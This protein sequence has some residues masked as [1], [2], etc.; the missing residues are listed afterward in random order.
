[1]L[2]NFRRKASRTLNR[3]FYRIDREMLTKGFRRI[4]LERGMSV[5]V[6]AALS[7]LGHIDGG[8]D[9]VIDAIMEI[10]GADGAVLMPS[11]PTG[12]STARYLDSG[13]EFDVRNSPSKVGLVSEIFRK[14]EGVDRSLHPTNPVAGWGAGAK[15]FLLDHGKSPTPYG[16]E[17]PYG[18]LAAAENG[19]ILMMETHVHSFLHHLQEMVDFPNLY[20]PGEREVSL[21][22]WDGA[23]RTMRTAVMRT[24]IPYFVAIPAVSGDEPDWAVLHDFALLFPRNQRRIVRRLG[25][26]FDGYKRLYERQ[27]ELER[28]GIFRTTRLGKGEIGLLQAGRFA[29][30]IKPEFSELIERFRRFYDPEEI[31]ARKLPYT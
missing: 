27:A 24:R 25:Y 2:H 10:V 21:I 4:G 11:Y 16:P 29:E 17:T 31:A 28:E 12:G 26:R 5:C 30:R 18:R 15:A 9:A 1:M 7:R 22:D 20:L 6:H 8:P 13:G 3:T 14:R 23:R 19:Y